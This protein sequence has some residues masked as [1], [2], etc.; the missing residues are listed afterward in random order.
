MPRDRCARCLLVIRRLC[1]VIRLRV[2]SCHVIIR[3]ASACFLNL[4]LS[5]FPQF[6][7]LTVLSPTTAARVHGTS[8]IVFYKWPENVLGMGWKLACGL[9]IV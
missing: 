5:G 6:R 2:A 1:H 9:I 4:H 3:I 8:E 7:P